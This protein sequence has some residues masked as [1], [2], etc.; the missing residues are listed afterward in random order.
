MKV[1]LYKG[2]RQGGREEE[3]QLSVKPVITSQQTKTD[4]S[5][6]SSHFNTEIVE[7]FLFLWGL[8]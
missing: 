5:K 2:G 8:V 1:G 3:E 6:Y 4:T 7:S